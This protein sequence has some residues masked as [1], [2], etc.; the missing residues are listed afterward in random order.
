VI[1][2]LRCSSRDYAF[3][4]LDGKRG[5]PK[6]IAQGL[7]VFP[8]GFS[9]IQSVVWFSHELDSLLDRHDCS[10]ILMKAFEGMTRDRSFVDRVEHETVAYFAAQRKGIKSVS[11][12]VKSTIAKDLGLKGRGRYLATLNTSAM[13]GFSEFKDKVQEAILVAWSGLS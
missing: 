7:V 12:K 1:L 6:L 11:R 10:Q 2:G 13:A 4:V 9:R 3:A 5:T 8:K